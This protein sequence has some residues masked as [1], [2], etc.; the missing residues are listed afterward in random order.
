M[1]KNSV[2]SQKFRRQKGGLKKNQ[3]KGATNKTEKISAAEFQEGLK[4]GKYSKGKKGRIK[5]EELLPEFQAML[6]SKKPEFDI[7]IERVNGV[8]FI[9]KSP[10]SV[11][12]SKKKKIALN[13]NIYRN[14]HYLVNNKAK[15]EYKSLMAHQIHQ[16]P[17]FK[18][19]K[20]EFILHKNSKRKLDRHNVNSI[21]EKFFADALVEYGKLID[22]NDLF[23]ESEKFSTGD[24]V[25]GTPYCDIII[26]AI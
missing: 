1:P 26:T 9:L 6:D 4:H 7:D 2:S 22:D 21:V 8:T 17:K 25:K 3:S 20:L 16:L 18:K 5:Q 10:I 12:V 23:I 13:L 19:I 24:N 14:L 15:K 11:M